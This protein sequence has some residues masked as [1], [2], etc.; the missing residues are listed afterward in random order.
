MLV[1]AVGSLGVSVGVSE[2][3]RGSVRVRGLVGVPGASGGHGH[4]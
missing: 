2:D 3:H 4:Q 1:V